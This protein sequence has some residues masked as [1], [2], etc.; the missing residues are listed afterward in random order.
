MGQLEI[1]N[2]EPYGMYGDHEKAG[3][4]DSGILNLRSYNGKTLVCRIQESEFRN[5]MV[6]LAV[7]HSVYPA[8]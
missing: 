6:H 4:Q 5:K 3:L 7:R 8:S 2:F 1:A